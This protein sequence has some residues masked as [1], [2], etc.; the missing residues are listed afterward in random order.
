M[1]RIYR[2]RW[3]SF[4]YVL[5]APT[6]P[7]IL[8]YAL[9]TWTLLASDR[10]AIDSF[11]MKCHWRI[12]QIRCHDFVCNSEVSLHTG[13]AFVFDRITRGRTA[14]YGHVARLP[15]NTPVS[16]T[17]GHATPSRAIGRSTHRPFM[18]TSTKPTTYQM[19]RPTPPRQ[20]QCS[21][22]DSVEASHWSQSLESDTTVQA[23]CTL[24]MTSPTSLMETVVYLI[25]SRSAHQ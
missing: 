13:L 18:E 8:L 10:K 6:V 16:S 2:K 24:T 1:S 19:D 22:C 3:R 9:E 4:R 11:R 20:Q 25:C 12:L 5:W 14:I 23:D 21:H 7:P 17:P 15:D